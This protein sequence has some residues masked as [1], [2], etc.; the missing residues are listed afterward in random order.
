MMTVMRTSAMKR[1]QLKRHS[2]GRVLDSA[3][4][5]IRQEGLGRTPIAA[6]MAD[7][8]LTHGTFYSHFSSKEELETAAFAQAIT[9][10]RPMWIPPTRG[11]AWNVRLCSLA[12]R[13]LT[14][15]HRDDLASSCGFS[16]LASEAAHATPAFRGAYERE[17]KGSL[18]AIC[19]GD[20]ADHVHLDDALALMVICVGGLSLSR[21]VVD[22][23]FSARILRVARQAAAQLADTTTEPIEEHPR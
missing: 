16:A 19:G 2:L 1:D 21:A 3:A 20:S 15:A 8:G 4:R 23:A 7:A 12:K 22:D 13:Y 10:G 5:R 17:L 6:V 18:N 11:E 14:A 9:T